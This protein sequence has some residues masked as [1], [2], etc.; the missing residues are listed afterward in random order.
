MFARLRL[1]P[2]SS[3]S[4]E[5]QLANHLF[6]LSE[7]GLLNHIHQLPTVRE[8][9]V[10]LHVSP[11]VIASA[12]QMWQHSGLNNLLYPVLQRAVNAGYSTAEIQATT[13][14]LLE[15]L[16]HKSKTGNL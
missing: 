12:Y 2:T 8:L 9:A 14:V 11:Q 13:A 7:S 5:E 15:E 6:A 16:H 10:Q 1:D 3:L 4:F